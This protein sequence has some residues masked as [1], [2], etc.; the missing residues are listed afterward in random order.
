V[1]FNLAVIVRTVGGVWEQ[2]D[3]DLFAAAKTLGASPLR[4][5]AEVTLPVLRPAIIAASSIVFLFTFT[6]YGVVRILGGPNRSTLEVEIYL[7]AVRLGDLGG[8]SAIAVVQLVAVAGL[9]FWWSRS[10]RKAVAP[11]RL[12][13]STE[14]TAHRGERR[15]A[16]C[17]AAAATAFVVVPLAGLVVRSVRVGDRFSLA[18]WRG[19]TRAE[20][21]P[22]IDLGLDPLGSIFVSLRYAT[23]AAA[24][25]VIIGTLAAL[26]ISRG[27]RTGAAL[28]TGLM[29]P[30]GTSAVTIGFGILLA[31][32]RP[33]LD[34]R[35][36]S[37]LVPF[38]HALVATPFVVRA[39]LPV[40]DAVPP[41]LRDAARTL[42]A[43]PL[44]VAREVDLRAASAA[45]IA[46]TGFAFAVSLGEFGATS[47]LS[48]RG[49]ETLPV[50]VERL[51]GRTGDL[52]QAQGAALA[53]VLLLVTVA[54]VAAVDRLAPR[55]TGA[56]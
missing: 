36:S 41:G 37:A 3:D 27:G 43:S 18:A 35:S 31:Y 26:A 54:V 11:A 28:D 9:L 13:P 45:I 53:T 34:F 16:I 56:W 42:G 24:L 29:L 12:A 4:T 23:A 40:L 50:A 33:P 22:G 10:Q 55:R 7:R 32:G 14:R 5:F 20:I 25:A 51:L 48:R 6:S 38:V 17:I 49:T 52:L 2:I 19:L 46:G 15:L 8:A 47:F 30:L 1:L 44:R 39:V 21:R